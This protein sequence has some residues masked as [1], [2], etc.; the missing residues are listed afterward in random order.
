MAEVFT[1]P[2]SVAEEEIK[3]EV[4]LKECSNPAEVAH[5][6]MQYTY[7]TVS[8][9][10]GSDHPFAQHLRERERQIPP[11]LENLRK[12]WQDTRQRGW[13]EHPPTEE[14][15]ARVVNFDWRIFHLEALEMT[16]I[17]LIC[18]GEWFP[19]KTP[20]PFSWLSGE[21]QGNCLMSQSFAVVEALCST[22]EEP[23]LRGEKKRGKINLMLPGIR[24]EKQPRFWLDLV[25]SI[26]EGKDHFPFLPDSLEQKL[27]EKLVVDFLNACKVF[28][29]GQYRQWVIDEFREGEGVVLKIKISREELKKLRG[30][31]PE[32]WGRLI[33]NLLHEAQHWEDYRQYNHGAL[34]SPWCFELRALRKE[35]ELDISKR[36]LRILEE[37]EGTLLSHVENFFHENIRLLLRLLVRKEKLSPQENALVD[38]MRAE[39]VASL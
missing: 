3:R 14:N 16:G 21:G 26:L 9:I 10:L 33:R 15:L 4:R 24:F 11:Y 1:P 28:V 29:Y 25:S 6:W 8:E 18:G 7:E 12:I 20:V 5:Q 30:E 36:Y 38:V 31:D 2:L 35:G 19:Q 27:R 13:L 39:V 32:V 23:I 17:I 34:I 22:W 37:K